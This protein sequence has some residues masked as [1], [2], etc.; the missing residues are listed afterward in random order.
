MKPMVSVIV[1][2]YNVE[3]FL[4]RCLESLLGQTLLEIEILCVDDASADGS[5]AVVREF[6]ERDSRVRLLRQEHKGVSAARNLGLEAARGEFVAFV[7]ADDW[8]ES[9]MLE[10]LVSRAEGCDVVVC[11]A[12][13]HYEDDS[14]RESLERALIVENGLWSGGGSLWECLERKGSWPFV[15]N[16]LYR[17]GLLMEQYLRFSTELSLG[18]DGAFLVLLW[19]Y[20]TKIAYVEKKLYHY[21]Y[22]RKSSATVRLYQDEVRRYGQHVDVVRVLLAEFAG[23]ALLAER[24]AE[25]LRWVIGFLYYDFVRLPA[26][27]RRDVSEKLKAVLTGQEMFVFS[28]GL[29]GFEKRRLKNLV[30]VDRECTA[31]KRSWDIWRLR[32]ENR[33]LK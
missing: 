21:R 23:R 14:R 6:A 27:E 31:V 20:A 13:V 33:I 5:A 24:G 8:V 4:P 7:D 11:S 29:R 1:P 28:Q 9:N 25:I 19:Q 3:K 30:N 18:E 22:L 10:A 17:R 12:Q 32:I 16:K 26:T 2:V 15:W